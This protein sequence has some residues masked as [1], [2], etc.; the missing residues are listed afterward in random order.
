MRVRFFPWLA[1]RRC[2]GEEKNP[3]LEQPVSASAEVLAAQ[4]IV[5]T[6][7]RTRWVVRRSS[8]IPSGDGRR[9]DPSTFGRTQCNAG[10]IHR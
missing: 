1:R 8:Y 3:N 4:A 5:T 6:L 2:A 7:E 10:P 9:T